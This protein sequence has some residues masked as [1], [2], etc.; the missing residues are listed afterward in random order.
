MAVSRTIPT[1]QIPDVVTFT[2]LS[3][4]VELPESVSVKHFIIQ[5]AVNKIPFA[6][7][8]ISDG[9]PSLED[10]PVSN[11]EYF[12]PGK[13]I[14]IRLGYRSDNSSLF[15]GLVI[16]HSNRISKHGAELII[17]CRDEAV[18]LTVGKKSRHFE[19]VSDGDAAEELIDNY[20]LEKEIESTSIRHK[21]LIQYNTTDWDF[22]L[23]RID[24]I[25]MIC[26]VE[27]GK[28]I[29]KKP[30]LTT[31]PVIELLFGA[32]ILDF[33]A[34]IDARTQYNE[35]RSL[36][37]DYSDQEVIEDTGDE[38]DMEEIGNL[39][40]SDL[41][42]VVGLESYD[43]IN[44]GKLSNEELKEY[45]NSKMLKSRLSKVRGKVR[46]Q[47]F[48]DVKPGDIIS[49]N[50]VG[51][52]FNGPVFASSV[53][54]EFAKG[55]WTTEVIFGMSENWFTENIN[56][57]DVTSKNGR[58]PSVQG[59]ETGIVTDLEDPEGENRVKVKLP[60][61]SN[62][63]DG[64]WMRIATLDAGKNRGTFFLPE[65]DDEVI[66]GFI[67]NDPNHP[68]IL[69]M[70]HSSAKPAPFSA[71]NSNDEKGYVS[72][73][74]TKMVFDDG[75]KTLTIEDANGNTIKFESGGI[76]LESTT[77]LNL[78]AA[79]IKIEASG[80]AEIKGAVVKIN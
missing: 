33:T 57:N 71:S 55:N 28:I 61:V 26:L 66:V 76:T 32:T 21:E 20:G 73:A 10:F 67:S 13:E 53:R 9:D 14:E 34:E 77:V 11:E 7:I 39:S 63:D 65:I 6:K 59:L 64:I 36:S 40:N 52:R 74:E 1:S 44:S 37:W 30:D 79:S 29:I 75:R 43:M 49:L 35:V 47:G 5:R 18:K 19:D 3:D 46:F 54:H 27:D 60:V 56:P 41:A 38:P 24:I 68:V 31:S 23:S 72:R 69:G 17:E 16:N 25:G 12:V 70:L 15:R 2:I 51:E 22:I 8:Y 78:K 58:L 80:P 45:A 48:P 50:G 4:G 62:S 42:E